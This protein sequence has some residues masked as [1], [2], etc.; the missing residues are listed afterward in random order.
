MIVPPFYP[1]GHQDSDKL[2]NML[3]SPRRPKKLLFSTQ[4]KAVLITAKCSKSL[5]LLMEKLCLS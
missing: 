2:E 5:M 4:T 3:K 1:P